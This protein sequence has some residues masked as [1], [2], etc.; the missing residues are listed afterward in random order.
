MGL[1]EKELE[2]HM[3][4]VKVGE[5][6]VYGKPQMDVLKFTRKFNRDMYELDMELS[7]KG[8]PEAIETLMGAMAPGNTILIKIKDGGQKTIVDFQNEEVNEDEEEEDPNAEPDEEELE[9]GDWEDPG[10][11][12]NE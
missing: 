1:R 3:G 10:T 4:L 8:E 6:H 7:I 9:E 11:G 5:S 2:T 12:D